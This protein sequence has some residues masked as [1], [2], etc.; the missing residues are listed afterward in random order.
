MLPYNIP[1]LKITYESIK[2]TILFMTVPFSYSF[3]EYPLEK[4]QQDL[5]MICHTAG[6]MLSNLTGGKRGHSPY[7]NKAADAV[8]QI[9]G[10][11]CTIMNPQLNAA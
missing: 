2:G 10:T 6:I 1:E 11:A 9:T 3:Y 4:I 8:K 7:Q 5:K